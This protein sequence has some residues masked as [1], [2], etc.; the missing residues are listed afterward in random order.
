[1]VKMQIIKERTPMPVQDPKERGQNFSEVALGFTEEM[2]LQEAKRCLK[3]KNRACVKGCPVEVPIPEFIALINEKDYRGAINKIK[4]KNVLPAICGR[5]CPQENQCEKFCTLGKIKESKP[6]GIGRLERFVADWDME[7]PEDIPEGAFCEDTEEKI[8]VAIIGAGPAGLTCAG[9]LA[10]KGYDVTIFE[11]F[12]KTGGVLVYGIPEFRLPK[13]IV[14][15]EINKLRD[16]GVKLETNKVIGQILT[17]EDLRQKGFKAFFVAVGAGLPIFLDI[18]GTELNGVLSANEILTRVNLMK[19]YDPEYDTPV[20][21]AKKVA[22]IGG[23]NVAMDSART[24]LRLGAEKVI[25][26]YR[27]SE[28]ELPARHE[29]YEHAVEEGI[30]FHF[31]RNPT[32]IIGGEDGFVKGLEV[33]KMELGEPDA[34]GRRRPIVQPNTEYI[35]D[36]DLVVMAI[37]ARANPLFTSQTEGL[38]LNKWGYIEVNDEL[39]TSLPDTFSGG[40]IVTGSA[41]VISAMGAGKQA[42]YGIHDYLQKQITE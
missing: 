27:R 30:E 35:L 7:H 28:K 5:V 19:A 39:Q 41:T 21:R 42:A 8:K 13:E 32:K 9:E 34:S 23:G 37:G 4:E 26:V 38:K 12:H 14:R 25:V 16:C 1:M 31:L 6:V 33:V 15:K 40:D 36:V 11:A 17:L 20:E 2:A 24:A 29:E 3:C 18:P 10:A 22:V